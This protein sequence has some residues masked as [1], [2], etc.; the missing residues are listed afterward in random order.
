MKD[1]Q[2]GAVAGLILAA[3]AS[4]R[5]G[6]PKQL[7]MLDGETLLERSVRVARV[8]GCSPVVVVLGAEAERILARCRLGDAIAVVNDRWAEGMAS[9]IRAGMAAF[10][11][12][13]VRGLILMVCDQ[14]AVTGGH[15][16]ALMHSACTM[17]S[18]YAGRRG[19]PAFF[20]AS[21]LD[22]LAALEGDAG[23]RELLQ[24]SPGIELAGGE[25]DVDTVEDLA[26]AG[27]EIPT[28]S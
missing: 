26:R 6:S 4:S 11:A 1:D 8:A 2:T 12:Q 9:S 21:A 20:P 19:V 27:C 17:A 18:R 22:G 5:L 3:G 15:L 7:A 24:S 14:P 13:S 16:R 28:S 10:D 23:A 25:L